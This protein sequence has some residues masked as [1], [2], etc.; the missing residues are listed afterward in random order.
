MIAFYVALKHSEADTLWEALCTYTPDPR[1]LIL[2]TETSNKS[3]LDISGQH[4]HIFAE[5]E[6]NTYEAFKKTIM[7]SKYNLRGQATENQSR[8]WGRVRN[9]REP[10]KMVAYTIK[11]KNYRHKNL[12]PEYLKECEAISFVK[13]DR[14]SNIEICLEHLVKVNQLNYKT[15]G[16]TETLHIYKFEEQVVEFWIQNIKDKVICK[17][18]LQHIVLRFLTQEY[19]HY[20]KHIFEILQFIKKNA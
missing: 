3:H 6:N 1:Q 5:W 8:Q 18:T 14:K 20:K 7:Q 4:F 19:P 2:A 10:D 15:L 17:S 16:E 13:E 9:I 11:H 12:D